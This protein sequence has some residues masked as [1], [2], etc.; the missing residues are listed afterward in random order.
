[1]TRSANNNNRRVL[2]LIAG[3]PLLIILGA[4]WLWRAVDSGQLDLLSLLG[5][6]NRG[7]LLQPPRPLQDQVLSD[8]SGERVVIEPGAEGLWSILIPGSGHCDSSCEDTLYYT[9]QI[10]TAMG[11]YM[12]RIQRLYLVPGASGDGGLSTTQRAEHPELKV[13][14][15]PATAYRALFDARSAAEAEPA[16]YIVDPQGWVMMY[17]TAD[18]DYRDVMA[19][20]KFLLKNSGG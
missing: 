8:I 9:R 4:T 20:L 6:A 13:L 11:K 15:T 16:Y 14:Y 12:G 5:T 2:L 17:Y 10:R 19:D 1:V 18:A 3:L 7:T